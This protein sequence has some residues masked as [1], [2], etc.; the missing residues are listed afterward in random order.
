MKNYAWEAKDLLKLQF[1]GFL[2]ASK[3]AHVNHRQ[4][5]RANTRKYLEKCSSRFKHQAKRVW[6]VFAVL[7][8]VNLWYAST[9]R[10]QFPYFLKGLLSRVPTSEKHLFHLTLQ[11]LHVECNSLWRFNFKNLLLGFQFASSLGFYAEEFF[12]FIREVRRVFNDLFVFFFRCGSI[13]A[14]CLLFE[15]FLEKFSD[16]FIVL[17]FIVSEKFLRCCFS[18]KWEF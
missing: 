13:R 15:R 2:K 10:L 5:E 4:I 8:Y 9:A 3:H 12:E 16:G 7:I 1:W 6:S 11:S 17:W 18:F 14:H